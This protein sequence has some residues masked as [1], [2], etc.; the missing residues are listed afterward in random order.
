M[1]TFLRKLLQAGNISGVLDA[2][3]NAF[4][5]IGI[6]W[7]VSKGRRELRGGNNEYGSTQYGGIWGPRQDNSPFSYNLD[8]INRYEDSIRQENFWGPGYWAPWEKDKELA[9]FLEDERWKQMSWEEW[10]NNSLN[11]L[12]RQQESGRRG[13]S[14]S[15]YNPLTDRIINATDDPS[16][17][18]PPF[19]PRKKVVAD[20]IEIPPWEQYRFNHPIEMTK[21]AD[22]FF[23][24]PT[25]NPESII[26]INR[27]RMW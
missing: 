18:E 15:R 24:N 4:K 25:L 8:E 23:N 13:R 14:N 1:F 21:Y 19:W 16:S 22:P 26:N 20:G 11:Q 2:S 5:Q 3:R 17:M 12:M 10:W 6:E 9:R 27:R 7:E